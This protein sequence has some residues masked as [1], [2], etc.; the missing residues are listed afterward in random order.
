MVYVRGRL[1][2][3]G[4][5]HGG[6]RKGAPSPVESVVPV[7]LIMP[8]KLVK[9]A[10]SSDL[11]KLVKPTEPVKAVNLVK[12]FKSAEC[13]RPS[14]RPPAALWQGGCWWGRW[15]ACW[16]GTAAPRTTTTPPRPSPPPPS[17]RVR[18]VI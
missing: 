11:I 10:E 13:N 5:W 8:F 7:R 6:E 2:T 17:I 12:P 18:L 1:R 14:A 16:A 4:G 15:C 9:L 3:C